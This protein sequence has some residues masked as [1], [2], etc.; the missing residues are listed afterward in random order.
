MD[1]LTSIKKGRVSCHPLR[2]TYIKQTLVWQ[3]LVHFGMIYMRYLLDWHKS[4]TYWNYIN[5]VPFGMMHF[6]YTLKWNVLGTF[7]NDGNWVRFLNDSHQLKRRGI[8]STFQ[9]HI[10]QADFGVTGVGTSWN[11]I[12]WILFGMAYFKAYL[13]WHTLGTIWNDIYWVPFGMTCIGYC[14]TLHALGTYIS[15]TL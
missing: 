3:E 15:V 10:H 11:Y 9:I 8:L 13:V 4:G 5:L 6:K 14:F 12:H 2:L 1:W 7:R